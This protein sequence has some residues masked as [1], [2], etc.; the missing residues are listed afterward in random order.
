MNK[1]LKNPITK[2]IIDDMVDGK[3]TRSEATAAVNKILELRVKARGLKDDVRDRNLMK[4]LEAATDNVLD[5]EVVMKS[6][7]EHSD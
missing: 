4:S 6:I 5:L 3:I 7:T 2:K 1:L